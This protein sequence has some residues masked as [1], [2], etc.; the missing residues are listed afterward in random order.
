[1]IRR[2]A[3]ILVLLTGLNL[4]NYLDRL[5]VSAVL[6]KIR[7]DLALSNF[8]AGALATVFL[9]GYFLT[10][11]LFG[12]LAD[13]GARKGLIALGVAVWSAATFA[14]GLARGAASLIGARAAVGVGEASYATLAPTIIDDIAPPERKGR[15]LAV[16]YVATPI[17]GALGYLVGGMLEKH[18][19]WRH[20]FWFCGGPGI[21]LAFLCLFIQEPVR[22]KIAEKADILGNASK[23]WGVRLYRRGVLGFCAYTFAIGGFS[24]WAPTFLHDR[25]GLEL[26]TANL[27]FGLMTVV[28]GAVGTAIGGWW[29][30]SEIKRSGARDDEAIARVNLKICAIGSLL[31]APLAAAC[32]FSTTDAG[33]FTW[34]YFAEVALFLTTS[35]INAVILRSVPTEIRAS[36]MALSIFAIHFLGDLW[37]PPLIGLLADHLSIAWAMM[38]VP[39]AIALAAWFWGTRGLGRE[40]GRALI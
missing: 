23:L 40:S 16:F 34:V 9:I 15:W 19:G 5:V 37:S 4:L 25:Y 24:F 1:M 11:P 35:P 31:G 39:L 26:A 29:A 28:S 32:F 27:C 36:A 12:A 17:G 18:F 20:A 2:P 38:A 21:A 14:S 22:K 10:S 6:P 33:F 8:V 7:D 13:K 30:D 3:T